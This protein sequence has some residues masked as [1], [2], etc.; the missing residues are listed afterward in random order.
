[1]TVFNIYKSLVNDNILLP[2]LIKMI[3][4]IYNTRSQDR[5]D[6]INNWD[7]ENLLKIK[8]TYL[9]GKE[10]YNEKEKQK[11]FDKKN[12]R[13]GETEQQKEIDSNIAGS[14][15][16]LELNNFKIGI[17]EE[18]EKT[19]QLHP[20]PKKMTRSKASLNL[21]KLES[22]QEKF[23]ETNKKVKLAGKENYSESSIPEFLFR[24]KS[25]EALGFPQLDS[26]DWKRLYNEV[27]F[28]KQS[29]KHNSYNSNNNGDYTLKTI[30]FDHHFKRSKILLQKIPFYLLFQHDE[31]KE[32]QIKL[33][34]KK[35]PNKK[36]TLILDLDET[37]IHSGSNINIRISNP[38]Y[39]LSNSSDSNVNIDSYNQNEYKEVFPVNIRPGLDNFLKFASK[40]FELGIFTA[41]SKDYADNI[42]ELIDPYN[43]IFSFRLYRNSCINFKSIFC[44]K[45]I[46]L[47]ENRTLDDI[48]I[49]DNNIMSFCDNLS[50]GYL[51]PSFYSDKADNEL[52]KLEKYLEKLM[53]S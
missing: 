28:D 6:L 39:D 11:E 38:N 44:I 36:K 49:V 31:L 34:P 41:S 26:F 50:N 15:F 21:V 27:C 13:Q 20:L 30:N 14:I 24:I 35:D 29:N 47:I 5:E 18:L 17:D 32:K 10:Y 45:P 51:I 16:E 8:P 12:Q 46:S 7:K 53:I 22:N 1:M 3:E 43:D 25:F 23:K 40:H 37:L 4:A 9:N 19:S 33:Q 42:L 52:E 2:N 48:I